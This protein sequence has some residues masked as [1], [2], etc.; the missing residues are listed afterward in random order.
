MKKILKWLLPNSKK[1]AGYAAE[2]I[3]KAVNESGKEEMIAKYGNM[4]DKAAAAAKW[5][6]QILKDGKIDKIEEADVQEKLVPLFDYML[7]L[8]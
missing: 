6:T 7:S 2:G 1:L 3:A 8:I 4:S 5:A